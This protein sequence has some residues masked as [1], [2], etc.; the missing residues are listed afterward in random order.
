MKIDDGRINKLLIAAQGIGVVFV[1]FFAAAYL[2]GLPTTNV[3]HSELAIR[4]PLAILGAILLF[5]VLIP[6]LVIAY[7]EKY[8]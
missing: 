2:F 3:L 6:S 7:L 1:G 5:F 8:D 4:I